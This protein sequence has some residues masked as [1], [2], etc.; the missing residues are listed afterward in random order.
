[1]NFFSKTRNPKGLCPFV[2]GTVNAKGSSPFVIG[3]VNAEGFSDAGTV[4][5]TDDDLRMMTVKQKQNDIY[6]LEQT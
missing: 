1:M 2:I 6:N 5:N 4:S 3:T